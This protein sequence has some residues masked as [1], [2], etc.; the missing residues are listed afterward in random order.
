MGKKDYYEVLGVSRS[1]TVEEIKK[2]YR[3]LAKKYHPDTHPGD[4]NAEERF[5]EINEA[6][7]VLSDP[8]KRAAYDQFGHAGVDAAAAAGARGG[9]HTQDFGDFG[10]DFEDL[11]GDV[12]EGFF[13]GTTRRRSRSRQS[14]GEDLQIDLDLTF[15]EAA[16]GVSKEIRFSKKER[17]EAC[18]GSGV[19]AQA[20]FRTCSACHGKGRI[21]YTQGFFTVAR[22]CPQCAGEGR[23]PGAPCP[24]C[25][26]EGR[27]RGEKVL[28]VKVPPGVEDGSRL[29][30]R[31]E[32][33][34]GRRGGAAGDL[35][36]VL[37]VQPHDFLERRGL[38]LYGEVPISFPVAA[39]GGEVEVP[40][41]EGAVKLKIPPGTPTGKM[42]RI[43][44]KG[45]QDP[46]GRKKGDQFVAVR[47]EVPV[48][49]NER[50]KE[51]L[52]EFAGTLH[53]ENQPES[54]SFWE[55]LRRRFSAKR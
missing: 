46:E 39:L 50:Q 28:A 11:F 45:L 54:A 23:I 44:G 9:F 10:M 19:K 26:G 34:A 3:T 20:G 6:Y 17:C 18:S 15:E 42:F 24:S 4:K 35:Y 40:T 31:G 29:R 13:G 1:A 32:G 14:A 8:Q 41:L 2:A 25:G 47:V 30:L 48:R 22:T 37:H 43:R 27:V 51:L 55:K 53:E 5:K 16:F 36:V 38:D 49:L 12:F 7:E 52:E 21:Q 33:E